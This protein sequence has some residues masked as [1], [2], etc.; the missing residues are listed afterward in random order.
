M[1]CHE[2][3]LLYRPRRARLQRAGGGTNTQAQTKKISYAITDLG[4]F[5]SPGNP[6]GAISINNSGQVAGEAYIDGTTRHACIWERDGGTWMVRDIGASAHYVNSGSQGINEWGQ[7]AGN[8][9]TETTGWAFFYDE[10]SGM[11]VF[12][13]EGYER[14]RSVRGINNRGDVAGISKIANLP[15]QA[16]VWEHNVDG[17]WTFTDLG[18]IFNLYTSNSWGINDLGQVVGSGRQSADQYYAS[19]WERN[20]G[21]DWTFTAL[22]GYGSSAKD[23]NNLGQVVGYGYINGTTQHPC[24]WERANGQWTTRDL[25]LP[26]GFSS[27]SPSAINNSGQVAGYA[28]LVTSGR[29]V[30]FVYK[31][32]I[33]DNVNNFLPAG[34]GWSLFLGTRYQ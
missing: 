22:G 21:G 30:G 31:D 32:G 29:M 34:S 26:S 16:S 10:T 33:M 15:T 23:V 28:Y 27:V 18:S 11:E 25:G 6:S 3:N 20:D 13:P 14:S 9:N 5:V 12:M 8:G 24:I 1:V 17:T 7:V 19:L 2:E 4:A